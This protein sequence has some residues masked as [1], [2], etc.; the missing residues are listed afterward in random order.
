MADVDKQ[1]WPE[2]SW[3]IGAAIRDCGAFRSNPVHWALMMALGSRV[4]YKPEYNGWVSFP[5]WNQIER[6]T[7]YK[8]RALKAA[9]DE[10]V[11]EGWIWRRPRRDTSDL[12]YFHT[13]K[14]WAALQAERAKEAKEDERWVQEQL[15]RGLVQAPPPSAAPKDGSISDEALADDTPIGDEPQAHP[16]ASLAKPA[17]ASQS[18]VV[19]TFGDGTTLSPEATVA[20]T[21]AN[22]MQRLNPHNEG[23]VATPDAASTGGAE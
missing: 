2:K 1:S 20:K 16:P 13:E 14:L 7:P 10:L 22:T 9:M 21:S 6:D 3:Q 18:R 5:G 4:S 12:T 15:K 19:V 23:E 8:Q 11:A 17:P